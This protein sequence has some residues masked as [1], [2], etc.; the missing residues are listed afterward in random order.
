M[1]C[2]EAGPLLLRRLEGRLEFD[3]G[4]RLERHLGQCES[5]RQA[6]EGQRFVASVLSARPV[7]EAPSGFPRRVM[8]SLEPDTSWL[9]VLNWR[10]WTFRLA[11]V[12]VAL[13]LVAALGFGTTEAAEPLEFSDLVA[14]WVVEDVAEGLPAFSLLWQEEVTDDTLLEAVLTADPDEPF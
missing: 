3:E 4:Q 2:D 1:Q 9:D 13:M 5:C 6:L 12:A 14:E 7:A 8:A 11:P 10:V